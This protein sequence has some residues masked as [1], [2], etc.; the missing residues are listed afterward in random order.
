MK[1]KHDSSR[2]GSRRRGTELNEQPDGEL[3]LDRGDERSGRIGDP[4]SP[5]DVQAEFPPERE[6]LAGMTGGETLEGDV[7]ADDMSPQTLLDEQPSH[8]PQSPQGR[9][10]ADSELRSVGEPEIGEGQGFGEAELARKTSAP[11]TRA[12]ASK[13]VT[14]HSRLLRRRRKAP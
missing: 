10:P 1:S 13:N 14:G 3:R 7:T 12:M 2:H 6:R 5:E 9:T 4:R 8:S 11:H